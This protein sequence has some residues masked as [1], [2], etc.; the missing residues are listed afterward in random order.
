MRERKRPRD[1]DDESC[2]AGLYDVFRNHGRKK[3]GS[4]KKKVAV[5]SAKLKETI[6]LTDE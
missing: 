6:D 4:G 3:Y 2:P 1:E 5:L